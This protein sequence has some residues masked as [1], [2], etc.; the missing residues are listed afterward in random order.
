M[1]TSDDYLRV[2]AVL[3]RLTTNEAHPALLSQRERLVGRL[4]EAALE[5]TKER[6][7]AL[8]NGIVF[9]VYV[10]LPLAD[11]AAK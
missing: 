3:P 4:R 1:Y 11:R 8:L 10:P 2:A 7:T 5:P 6:N 9:L